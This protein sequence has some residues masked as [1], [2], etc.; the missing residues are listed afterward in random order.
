MFPDDVGFISQPSQG[1][2][3]A[4]EEM[5]VDAGTRCAGEQF[6]SEVCGGLQRHMASIAIVLCVR[7]IIKAARSNTGDTTQQVRIVVILAS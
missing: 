4:G 7:R 5:V 1:R 2:V 6:G 3:R